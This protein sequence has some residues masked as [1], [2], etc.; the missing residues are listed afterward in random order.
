MLILLK[1][2]HRRADIPRIPA[3]KAQTLPFSSIPD[4]PVAVKENPGNGPYD[5][6]VH[7]SF[8]I[9]QDRSA[10]PVSFVGSMG[11][12]TFLKR[13][14]FFVEKGCQKAHFG[15]DYGADYLA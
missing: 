6:N 10:R 15:V 13:P 2:D 11:T 7:P 4:Y 8:I 9:R 12:D 5:D 1:T 14:C 3:H